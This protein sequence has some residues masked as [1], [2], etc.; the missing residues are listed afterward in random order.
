MVPIASVQGV[1]EACGEGLLQLSDSLVLLGA[2]VHELN[3]ASLAEGFNPSTS[4][5]Q[6]QNIPYR[7]QFSVLKDMLV[8]S[9]K[10]S[11]QGGR[12]GL[13]LDLL[14]EMIRAHRVSA[15]MQ[16]QDNRP[17]AKTLP[18]FAAMNLVRSRAIFRASGHFSKD[19]FLCSSTD[20]AAKQIVDDLSKSDPEIDRPSDVET[21]SAKQL[22]SP[23]EEPPKIN[24]AHSTEGSAQD[25]L[26]KPQSTLAL[27]ST[28]VEPSVI[29]PP[30]RSYTF[31]E[32]PGEVLVSSDL[33]TGHSEWRRAALSLLFLFVSMTFMTSTTNQE[34]DP[35]SH[36]T[37]LQLSPTFA[38]LSM[39]GIFSLRT[40]HT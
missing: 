22:S 4:P 9:S 29:S 6:H 11:E 27:A 14:T 34:T 36:A 26:P 7:I 37:V 24:V 19:L 25:F 3:T 17:G 35:A 33:P 18:M 38:L 12:R 21:F 1:E 32:Q 30:N 16:S 5:P 10:E 2:N 13:W 40:F 15:D 39:A 20:V 23:S 28:L 8:S 31:K